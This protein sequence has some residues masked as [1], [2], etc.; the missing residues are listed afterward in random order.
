MKTLSICTAGALFIAFSA[1]APLPPMGISA[2]D[3]QAEF[4]QRLSALCGRTLSGSMVSTEAVDDDMAGKPMR[5]TVASCTAEEI[6]I[7]FHVGPN[8]PG[9]KWDTSRTWVLRRT[10]DG[11]QLKHDHRHD[12]G[13]PDAVTNYGGTAP[14]TT[15][16]PH[17]DAKGA[18]LW[19]DFPVD[20][21]SVTNFRANGLDKSVTNVWSVGLGPADA[22][23]GGGAPAFTYRLT[24]T[25][26]HA[27]HFEVA[28]Y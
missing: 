13:T 4:W 16:S 3:Q 9:G 18:Q 5:M 21:E 12:D 25:G 6:L 1:C 23:P 20:A 22:K 10:M 2:Q 7:P 24:R 19:L 11:V 15:P 8:E 17:R 27:R 28:F 14:L 26:E